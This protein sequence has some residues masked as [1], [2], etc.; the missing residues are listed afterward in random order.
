MLDYIPLY[1]RESNIATEKIESE[2]VEIEDLNEEIKDVLDQFFINTAT[3]GLKY[4]EKALNIPID[5]EKPYDQRR[6]KINSRLRGM[7]VVTKTL[8]KETAEAYDGGEVDV[9]EKPSEYK[10]IVTFIDTRGVPPNLD[11]TKEALREIIPAHLGVDFEFTYLVWD[12]LDGAEKTWNW[13]D[14]Q[15]FTWDEFETEDPDDW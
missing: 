1:Y 11:D 6:S 12:E 10:V 13:L 3:W 7:G 14:E 8:I 5:E 9:E 15:N 2:G 4:W